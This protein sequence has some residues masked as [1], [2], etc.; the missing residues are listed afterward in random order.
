MPPQAPGADFAG[1]SP[2]DE[3]SL[4]GSSNDFR[5]DPTSK[6]LGAET[7]GTPDHQR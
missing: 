4:N 7:P 3:E 6:V 5:S 2:A 1:C